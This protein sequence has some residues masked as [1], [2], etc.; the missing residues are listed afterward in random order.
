MSN[1][2]PEQRADRNGK[3][4]TRH[5][6][7]KA[8]NPSRRTIAPPKLGKRYSIQQLRLEVAD[9]FEMPDEQFKRM[10]EPDRLEGMLGLARSHDVSYAAG[11]LMDGMVGI[12]KDS[13]FSA[14]LGLLN[15]NYTIADQTLA[16]H[17]SKSADFRTYA[18]E[19]VTSLNMYE[20]EMTPEDEALLI[21][22]SCRIWIDEALDGPYFEE[23]FPSDFVPNR[24]RKG[25]IIG[26]TPLRDDLAQ[27]IVENPDKTEPIISIVIE[28]RISDPKA[29]HELLD[30][31]V[32]STLGSGVL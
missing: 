7:P 4:V 21:S 30:G 15:R 10:T 5:V 13:D 16:Q 6:K 27:Y 25:R 8:E 11:I 12:H 1:L 22:T 14:C 18:P 32:S 31:T 3:I 2:I 28:R 23:V 19:L 26:N 29:I 20:F 24:E 9:A 17:P